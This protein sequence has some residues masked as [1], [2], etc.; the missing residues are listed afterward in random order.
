M[1]K[2]LCWDL[3]IKT[4]VSDTEGGWEAAR[5]GDCGISALVVSD[6]DTRR[7]HLYDEHTLDEAVDHLNS[8]DLLVGFNTLEFDARVLWGVTGRYITIPQYDILSEIWN[9]IGVR[10]KGFKLNE[11]ALATLNLEKS[12]KGDFAPTLVAQG[13]YA[14]LFDYCL[15]DVH[16]VRELYNHIQDLGWIR[17]A[18]G[19]QIELD[20]PVFAEYA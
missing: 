5:N 6:S 15:N 1:S 18:G 9:T 7:F 10:T 8:A 4:P 3:E 16:L 14:E 11:I 2:I 17:G 19:R 20:R 12:G 13:R